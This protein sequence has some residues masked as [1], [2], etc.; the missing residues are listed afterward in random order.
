MRQYATA[1]DYAAWLPGGTAT[2]RE[3]GLASLVVDGAL[4]GVV[5][6]TD[7]TGLP[8][9]PAVAAALRDA[10]CAVVEASQ[11]PAAQVGQIPGLKAATIGGVR[12]ELETAATSGNT[13]SSLPQPARQILVNAGLVGGAVW[14]YG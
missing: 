11:G 8:T 10:V 1:A 9:D 12:Y 13:S 14:V 7:D 4:A 5:Y 2:D 3:L 6:L